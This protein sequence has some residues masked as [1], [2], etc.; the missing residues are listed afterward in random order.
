MCL[1]LPG[2]ILEIHQPYAVCDIGGVERRVHLGII[3]GAAVGEYVLVHAG[4]AIAKIDGAEAER[5]I[6]AIEKIREAARG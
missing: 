6:A 2:K 4:F 1:A 3:D 5:T